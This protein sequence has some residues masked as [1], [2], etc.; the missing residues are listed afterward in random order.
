MLEK[1]YP[2]MM[3][4]KVQNIQLDLLKSKGI[5]GLMLDIDNTLVPMNMMDA[6]KKA[7][8]WISQLK[9]K[10]FKVCIVSNASSKRVIR[11]NDKLQVM[12]F[13]RASKPG[14]KIFLR[15]AREMGLKTTE[16]CMVG[17]QIF[18]DIWGGNRINMMTILV[19]PIDKREVFWVRLKRLPEKAVIAFY[20]KR[21]PQQDELRKQWKEAS[22]ERLLRK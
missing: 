19:Q 17:D 10:G 9:A 3:A 20:N 11:F 4:D 7:V 22:L 21:N 5:K 1:F 15:A 16:V 12:A 6:D 8:E 18:T 2:D 14:S 13:H